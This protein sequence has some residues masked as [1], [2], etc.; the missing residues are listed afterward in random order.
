MKSTNN[1]TN[2]SQAHAPKWTQTPTYNNN[3]NYSFNKK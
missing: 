2:P 1:T 3:A